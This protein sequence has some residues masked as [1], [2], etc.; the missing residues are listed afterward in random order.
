MADNRARKHAHGGI[1]KKFQLMLTDEASAMLDAIASEQGI[2]RSEAIER[3]V[4]AVYGESYGQ[5]I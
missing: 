3:M 5:E 2:T 1:K 4:R